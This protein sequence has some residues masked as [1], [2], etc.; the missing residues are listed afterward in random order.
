MLEQIP[1]PTNGATRQW[2]PTPES[3]RSGSETQEKLMVK[4][5]SFI[6]DQD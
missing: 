1:W 3:L 6:E 5:V 4:S 2:F